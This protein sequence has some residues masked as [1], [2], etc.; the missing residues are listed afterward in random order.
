VLQTIIDVMQPHYLTVEMEPQTQE[1]NLK[2]LVNYSSDSVL[3]YVQHYLNRLQRRH[4][5]IGAGAGTWDE[6]DYFVK[7][8]SQT[9]IDYIDFH[10]YPVHFNYFDD[11]VYKID[12]LCRR[13]HKQLVIGEAWCY[14]AT[15]QE[16]MNIV[17]P[18]AASADIFSRD[19]FDY[20]VPIDT[21]FVKAVIGF[22]H[23]ARARVTSF[24]W[25]TLMYAYL[26][27]DPARHEAMPHAERLRA[28]QQAGFH[29]MLKKQLSATGEFLRDNIARPYANPA[30]GDKKTRPTFNLSQNFPNPFNPLTTLR[31]SL[32]Q[33]LRVTI[34]IHNISGQWVRTLID[35]EKEAGAHELK[36]DASN[37]ASGTYFCCFAAGPV[38]E[39][40]KMILQR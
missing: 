17:N 13:H 5:L 27:Y 38:V 33:R 24:F 6:E 36:F 15:N 29:N 7:L 3:V 40:R 21:M 22:S 39:T 28:G 12:D 9:R 16:M 19:M 37:L 10:I 20:W 25:P 14:K 31:F 35:Q 30:A 32:P 34:S 23:L 8:A 11:L 1:L 18:V 26:T 4:T 2:H